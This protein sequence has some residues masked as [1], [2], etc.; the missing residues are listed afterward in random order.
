MIKKIIIRWAINQIRELYKQNKLDNWRTDKD[1]NIQD[2][3]E[4]KYSDTE[5]LIAIKRNK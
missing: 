2:I 3:L 4:A 5:I 1:Y